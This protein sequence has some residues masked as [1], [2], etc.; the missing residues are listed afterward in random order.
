M[1]N[2]PGSPRANYEFART[3][4]FS[5]QLEH[6]PDLTRRAFEGLAKCSALPRSGILCEQGSIILSARMGQ[7]IDPALWRSVLDKLAAAPPSE[8]DIGALTEL[9]NCQI[10]EICP[11]DERLVEA[12]EAA[13]K[14]ATRQP[15]LSIVHGAYLWRLHRA[16]V[17]AEKAIRTAVA[18]SPDEPAY[19]AYL[20]ELLIETGQ[21]TAA[22]TELDALRRLDNMGSLDYMLDPLQN[23]LDT[24][25]QATPPL[26]APGTP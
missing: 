15:R 3:L 22:Q 5:P 11:P 26:P 21:K 23:A 6:N 20:I 12:M 8:S 19:R 17:P 18:E 1:S 9:A 24:G 14:I 10:N 16:Y 2:N 13:R 25:A 7:T 4:L